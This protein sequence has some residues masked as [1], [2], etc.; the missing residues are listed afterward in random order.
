MLV[1]NPTLFMVHHT[2]VLSQVTVYSLSRRMDVLHS[3]GQPWEITP[4]V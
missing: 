3:I 4:T 1:A 2:D